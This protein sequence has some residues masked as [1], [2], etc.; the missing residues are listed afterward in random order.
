M[1]VLALQ[2]FFMRSAHGVGRR[3]ITSSGALGEAALFLRSTAL[4]DILFNFFYPL[5]PQ[6]RANRKW[7]SLKG[8]W[9]LSFTMGMKCKVLG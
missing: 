6:L 7:I 3:S 9:S 2:L 8:I 1:F 5:G 4:L